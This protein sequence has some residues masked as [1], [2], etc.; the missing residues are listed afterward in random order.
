MSYNLRLIEGI[1][2]GF[3]PPT[4]RASIMIAKEGDQAASIEQHNLKPHTSNDYVSTR[5]IISDEDLAQQMRDI[6][7]VL[8]GLPVESPSG[9]EDIYGLDTSI[10]FL[11]DDL[12]WMN[13]GPGGCAQGHGESAVQATEEQKNAFAS[14]VDKVK[15]LGQAFAVNQM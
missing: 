15:S 8:K 5:G 7:A 2:G 14:I 11:S 4:M 13:G 10:A 9:S 3:A 12:Q 6:E 1:T